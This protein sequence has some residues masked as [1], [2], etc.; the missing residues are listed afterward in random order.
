MH[1]QNNLKKLKI[2]QASTLKKLKIFISTS[3]KKNLKAH[4]IYQ[5]ILLRQVI[6]SVIYILTI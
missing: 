1:D 2:E 4:L 6:L 5:F 3:K